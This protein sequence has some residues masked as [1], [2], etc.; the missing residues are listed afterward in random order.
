MVQGHLSN[1]HFFKPEGRYAK[2]C[3]N[4][5]DKEIN[6]IQIRILDSGEY[7]DLRILCGDEKFLVHKVVVCSQS[8]VL[9]A[10]MKKGFKVMQDVHCHERGPLVTRPY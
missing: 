4:V 6:L 7:S 2:V 10:A 8:K 9:A 3:F 1:G 5:V